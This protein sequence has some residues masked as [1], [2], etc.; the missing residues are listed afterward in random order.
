MMACLRAAA[1]WAPER[2][3]V[4]AQ[5][6]HLKGG[7]SREALSSSLPR[8]DV[9]TERSY[10]PYRRA[11]EHAAGGMQCAVLTSNGHS[12]KTLASPDASLLAR[13]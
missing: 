5:R 10:P 9:P 8:S 2:V 13:T 1:A 3:C 6:A 11:H 7:S 12:E 4:R